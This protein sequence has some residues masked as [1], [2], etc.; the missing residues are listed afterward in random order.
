MM[1]RPMFTAPAHIDDDIL[2]FMESYN[3]K[4]YKDFV[5][6]WFNDVLVPAIMSHHSFKLGDIQQAVYRP[7]QI[8]AGD[9]SVAFIEWYSRRR[10]SAAVTRPT[11]TATL[12]EK[13]SVT[14]LGLRLHNRL[15]QIIHGE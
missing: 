11:E 1:T 6:P 3:K 5:N 12:A 9:W 2:K 15:L 14:T 10:K 13:S 8:T 7:E 4:P